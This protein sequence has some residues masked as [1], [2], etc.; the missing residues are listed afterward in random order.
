MTTNHKTDAE[1]FAEAARDRSDLWGRFVEEHP[2][3]GETKVWHGVTFH[4]ASTL[5]TWVTIP[6]DN[7]LA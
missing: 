7:D 3:D 1:L 2:R 5:G 6:E 4:W